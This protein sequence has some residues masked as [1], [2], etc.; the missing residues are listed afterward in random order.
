MSWQQL[1]RWWL[2]EVS[3][4]AYSEE[5]LP[6]L[7][8]LLQPAA[9]ARYLDVGCGEGRVM[10]ALRDVG[11]E[12]VGCDGS[13]VLLQLARRHA[14]VVRC[15]LP[16]LGWARPASF[17]G[18]FLSLVLEHLPDEAEMLAQA[19]RVVRP[20]GVLVAVLN[21][22]FFTAVGSAPIVD[23]EDGEVLWRVGE[24]LGRGYTDEPAADHQLV[25]FHHRPMGVL[26]TAAAEAGWELRRLEERGVSPAQ[27]ERV[28]SLAGQQHI[29][30]LL[31]VRWERR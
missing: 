6:L 23:P 14:P 27:A 20:G 25:R 26:L 8:D 1:D 30:R 15:E 22:P 7:I 18:A 2:E 3:D 24:Y 13:P 11:A 21:H 9:G 12:V 19:A 5:V 29:P 31:G 16:E 17:D 10:A 4:P 28:P